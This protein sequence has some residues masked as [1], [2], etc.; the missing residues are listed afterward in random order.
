MWRKIETE[1][2]G[3]VWRNPAVPTDNLRVQK[4]WMDLCLNEGFK[5]K[6]GDMMNGAKPPPRE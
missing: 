6:V 3:E 4:R 2:E 1:T 5:R